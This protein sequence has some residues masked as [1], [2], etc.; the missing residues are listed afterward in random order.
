MACGSCQ[1][2]SVPRLARPRIVFVP[3]ASRNAAP[4]QQFPAT[5]VVPQASLD[6]V[7]PNNVYDR[8]RIERLQREAIKR[9]KG[10]I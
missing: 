2:R 7:D 4:Q 1:K 6:N 8:K 9:A 5:H 3:G 10:Y